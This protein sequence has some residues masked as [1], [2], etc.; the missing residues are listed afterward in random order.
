MSIKETLSGKRKKCAYNVCPKWVVDSLMLIHHGA[1]EYKPEMIGKIVNSRWV[2]PNGGLWTSPMGSEYGWEKWCRSE[3]FRIE[4]LS[5]S[6]ALRVRPESKI[7]II[8]T[9]EDLLKLPRLEKGEGFY[10]RM[11][12]DFEIIS[13]K[14]DAVWLTVKGQWETRHSQPM[15]LYGWD[16]E[17]VLIMNKESVYQIE[18]T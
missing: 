15:N 17:T 4:N 6:F 7:L 18:K 3:E 9:L 5:K 12:L 2:K 16:C 8:D 14:F 13:N 10:G 11:Y 1:S